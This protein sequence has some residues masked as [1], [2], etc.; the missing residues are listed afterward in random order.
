MSSEINPNTQHLLL[1][2]SQLLHL[3]SFSLGW[4]LDRSD[5][6][7]LR[8]LNLFLLDG[9]LLFSLHHFD[10]DLLQP[11][12][13]LLFS[14]LQFISQLRLCFLCDGDTRVNIVS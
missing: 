5:E 6:L 13:L 7:H 14:S 12:F 1:S 3:I 9:D 4:T 8:P 11:D 2:F 10:L